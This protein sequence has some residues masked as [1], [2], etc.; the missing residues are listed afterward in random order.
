MSDFNPPEKVRQDIADKLRESVEISPDMHRI[1]T[2]I[3]IDLLGA[4]AEALN[5]IPEQIRAKIREI[6]NGGFLFSVYG[7]FLSLWSTFDLLVEILIMRELKIG[8]Q[9]NSIVCGGL[10]F[11]PKISI[12][13]SLLSRHEEVDQV[14]ISLLRTCQETANR[15]SFAHGFFFDN[16]NRDQLSLIRRE[17]KYEYFVSSKEIGL[18][19]MARHVLKFLELFRDVAIHFKVSIADLHEYSKSI[20]EQVPIYAARAARRRESQTSSGKA[21]KKP[22]DQIQPEPLGPEVDLPSE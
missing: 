4:S 8:L 17:V 11:G 12:L 22:P 6:A 13:Y 19:Q 18:K 21:K 7:F 3:L 5:E 15:N 20:A 14:G 9:E 1:L 2:D 10:M 16:Q